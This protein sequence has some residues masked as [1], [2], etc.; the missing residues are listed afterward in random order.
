M[1]WTENRRKCG[2]GNSG[3]YP[4]EGPLHALVFKRPDVG[5]E[6]HRLAI[7]SVLYSLKECTNTRFQAA[8]SL[9]A[10]SFLRPRGAA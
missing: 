3:C 7:E 2:I 10:T 4:I 8:V 9:R 1:F 5:L 6:Q